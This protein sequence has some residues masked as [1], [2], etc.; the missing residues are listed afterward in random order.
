MSVINEAA[1]TATLAKDEDKSMRRV[2]MAS[3]IG[4]TVEWYDFLLYGTAAALI[5]N[6][7][8]FLPLIQ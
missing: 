6:R 5:F 8:F 2:V 4:T 3:V 7:L 1:L